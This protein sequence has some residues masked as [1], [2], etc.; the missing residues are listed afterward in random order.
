MRWVD[1][2]GTGEVFSFV[3]MHQ[4]YHPWFAER[5]PYIVAEIKLSEGPRILSTLVD[6]AP[7]EVR[8]GQ[9]VTVEFQSCNE[10]I[11]LPVFRVTDRV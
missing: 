5:A 8:I 6:I 1:A 2:A 7:S 9:A 11:T 10:H 3:V 4:I